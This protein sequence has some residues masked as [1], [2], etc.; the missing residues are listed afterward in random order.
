MPCDAKTVLAGAYAKGFPR[1][2]ERA[3]LNCLAELLRVVGGTANAQANLVSAYAAGLLKLSSRAN[4]V[5]LTYSYGTVTYATAAA[6]LA[7]AA[8]NGYN[9]LTN[10]D[11]IGCIV[12]ASGTA[13]SATTLNAAA[14]ASGFDKL[15]DEALWACMLQGASMGLTGQTMYTNAVAAG[16]ERLSDFELLICLLQAVCILG[17][18]TP[19]T[20]LPAPNFNGDSPF[21]QTAPEGAII[22]FNTGAITNG[23]AATIDSF[24]ILYGQ[25]AGGPYP[26]TLHQPEILGNITPN[27]VYNFRISGL[28]NGGWFFVLRQNAGACLG[29]LSTEGSTVVGTGPV[30]FTFAN[31]LGDANVTATWNAPPIGVTAVELWTSTDNITYNL[32]ATVAAPGTSTTVAQPTAGNFLWGKIRYKTAT[33]FGLFTSPIEVSGLLN[34]LVSYWNMDS[35][36]SN[37]GGQID[38]FGSTNLVNHLGAGN[39]VKSAAGLV[40]N[41]GDW[42][43]NFAN[44]PFLKVTAPASLR[45]GGGKSMTAAM[46]VKFSANGNNAGVFGVFN[47]VNEYLLWF[48]TT[49]ALEWNVRNGAGSNIALVIGNQTTGTWHLIVVGFDN[50]NNQLFYSIDGGARVNGA[51]V[52][53]SQNGGAPNFEL[54]NYADGFPSD[55]FIDEVG[56][57][58]RVL[59]AA[60]ITFLYNGGVGRTL[61]L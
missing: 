47:P 3:Q 36:V 49:P 19:C 39:E 52:G 5:C 53:A 16:Y 35:V 41:C 55:C 44:S 38:N 14:E 12:Q 24:D 29:T 9:E 30:G 18:L 58:N 4:L 54:G 50:A 43:T 25:T 34:G 51:C 21:Y 2:S 27:T 23:Q 37:P 59:N 8:A 60:E 13:S 28:A 26:N 1:L 20:P 61:P 40:N 6:A 11:I 42:H 46:W 33:G 48:N 45:L 56:W 7:A 15:S 17:S 31:D 32:A 57:W 22:H 10:R